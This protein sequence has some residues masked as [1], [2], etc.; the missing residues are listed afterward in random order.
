MSMATEP[1]QR[2]VYEGTFDDT[3]LESAVV[4]LLLVPDVNGDECGVCDEAFSDE[5]LRKRG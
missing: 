2:S 1:K 5:F 4:T 3:M